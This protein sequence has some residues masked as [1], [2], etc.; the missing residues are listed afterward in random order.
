MTDKPILMT[1]TNIRAILDDRKWQTRR[2]P[3]ITGHRSISEFG[4]SGTPGYDWHFRDADMRWHDLTQSEL[5]AR[6]PWQVGDRL[7]VKETCAT[8]IDEPETVSDPVVYADDK[9]WVA[10]KAEAKRTEPEWKVRSPIHM[11]RWASRLTLTVTDVRVQRVQD[12]SEESAEAEGLYCVSKDGGRTW[13]WGIPD[14]DGVPGTDDLGWPWA[15]WE[16][17]P[18]A[19][20]RRLWDGLNAKRG[21]GWDTNPWV[22]ALSFN[23]MKANIDA[24]PGPI[25]RPEA[26]P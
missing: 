11:P 12:I 1:A 6:L 5:M 20:Y 4:R 3:R 19:A 21:F 26:R 10:I 13:K 17:S 23:V 25:Q 16:T 7:W 24:L 14:R 22:A 15:D 9:D 2:L 8:W 18:R